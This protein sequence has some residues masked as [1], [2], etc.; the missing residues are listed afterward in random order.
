M[1]SNDKIDK[2]K[3]AKL[4]KEY[5]KSSRSLVFFWSRKLDQSLS[6]RLRFIRALKNLRQFL[7]V[8][9]GRMPIPKNY[10]KNTGL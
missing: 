6:S 8:Y 2:E 4:R 5:E 7:D 9:V 10:P 1:I 3:Y